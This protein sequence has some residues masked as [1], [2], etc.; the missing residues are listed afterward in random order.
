MSAEEAAPLV[1]ALVRRWVYRRR[2]HAEIANDMHADLTL[3]DDPPIG[4]NAREFITEA[5]DD[6]RITLRQFETL[7]RSWDSTR[8]LNA[9]IRR[10]QQFR[11]MP[12]GILSDE[13]VIEN[14]DLL[15]SMASYFDINR[16]EFDEALGI[17]WYT[18]APDW[19]APPSLEPR[20]VNGYKQWI[21][22][23]EM[24]TR[25]VFAGN[26]RI[27]VLGIDPSLVT[28]GYPVVNGPGDMTITESFDIEMESHGAA[29][30]VGVEIARLRDD[31][32]A[33]RR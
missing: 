24:P 5:R 17:D 9:R 11:I 10:Q 18:V 30:Q 8:A 27:V 20:V 16:D 23:E 25:W 12:D 33:N 3:D 26:P 31:V 6:G 15:D 21:Q 32:K 13:G 19:P 4:D 1:G 22:I 29:E 14:E 28:V 7:W 2:T